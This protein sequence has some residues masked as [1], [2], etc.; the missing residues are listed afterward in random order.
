MSHS[1]RS[2][3]FFGIYLVFLG[4]L[5]VFTPNLLLALVRI[6]ATNEIWIRLMGMLLTFMGFFYIM[7][8]WKNIRPFFSWTLVTRGSAVFFLSAFVLVKWI[9]PVVFLFW[10]GDL[11]GALWTWF[12]LQ[13]EKEAQ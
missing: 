7:A 1:A 11:A 12:A 3:F 4:F 5:L 6:P 10:L 2:I 13:S 8:G 9:S